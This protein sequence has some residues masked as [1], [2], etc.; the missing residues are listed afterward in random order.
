MTKLQ[1]A[2][3]MEVIDTYD[4]REALERDIMAADYKNGL[5]LLGARR[6]VEGGTFLVYYSD[7]NDWLHSNGSDKRI[8]DDSRNW[9]IYINVISSAAFR[10]ATER[11][12]WAN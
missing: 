12:K 7:I 8:K 6:L 9:N 2:A 1:Q 11:E 10:L 4:N 3:I 5:T